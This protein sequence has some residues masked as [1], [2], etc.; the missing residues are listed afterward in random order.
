MNAAIPR[1]I[2]T[3]VDISRYST[4]RV[5]ATVDLFAAPANETEVLEI[6]QYLKAEGL[7]WH[8]LGGGSNLL[9]SSRGLNGVVISTL[10]MREIKQ[11]SEVSLEFGAGLR[12]PRLCSEMTKHALAG[13]NLWKVFQVQLVAVLS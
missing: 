9:L 1:T 8:I 7:N 5:M 3:N 6:F 11:L 13:L 10:Q 4:L 2:K 12:M